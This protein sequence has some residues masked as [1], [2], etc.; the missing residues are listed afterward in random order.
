M[1]Y[2][3]FPQKTSCCSSASTARSTSG[4]VCCGSPTWRRWSPGNR[5]T[6]SAR[7]RQRT[8]QAPNACCTWDCCSPLTCSALRCPVRSWGRGTLRCRG[9]S[10][11]DQI[12]SRLPFANLVP[13]GTFRSAAFRARMKGGLL[14]GAG[15]LLRL[16]LYPT[17]EDWAKDGEGKR[18]WLLDAMAGR[19]GWSGNTAA[20]AGPESLHQRPW[21][22]QKSLE[23]YLQNHLP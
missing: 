19:S 9:S 22:C 21:M 20:R 3:R 11:A 6:G 15:Y 14:R 1:T 23:H 10:H 13:A 2:R 17:E 8:K 18:P 5:L 4:N 12:A 16:S 7:G